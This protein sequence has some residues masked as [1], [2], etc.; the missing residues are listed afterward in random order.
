MILL[1][2]DAVVQLLPDGLSHPHLLCQP[3]HIP[4]AVR[5]GVAVGVKD[6]DRALT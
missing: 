1:R 2:R 4:E 6:M 5:V 3:Q